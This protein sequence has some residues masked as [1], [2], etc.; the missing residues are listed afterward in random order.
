MSLFRLRER[1]TVEA[2]QWTGDNIEEMAR[3]VAPPPGELPEA[4]IIRQGQPFAIGEDA[5]PVGYFVAR[6]GD[7]SLLIFEP[8]RFAECFELVA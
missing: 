3:H 7:G 8:G 5:V 4:S 6:D 1:L 2:I